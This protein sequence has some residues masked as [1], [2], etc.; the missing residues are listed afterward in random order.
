MTLKFLDHQVTR[1]KVVSFTIRVNINGGADLGEMRVFGG[2]FFGT[3]GVWDT[4]GTIKWRYQKAI[5]H[6]GL[7]LRE[8]LMEA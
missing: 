2:F 4:C 7:K 5:Y 1:Y 3:Y 8:I 6:M